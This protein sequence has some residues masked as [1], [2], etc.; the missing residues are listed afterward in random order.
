MKVN[1]VSWKVNK[2]EI[3]GLIGPL[4]YRYRQRPLRNCRSRKT[5]K[6]CKSFPWELTE[7]VTGAILAKNSYT[8]NGVVMISVK[9]ASILK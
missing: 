3:V 4:E 8:A 5:N 2:E 6:W 9:S 1:N 7:G